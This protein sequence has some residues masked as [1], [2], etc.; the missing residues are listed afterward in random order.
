M[1]TAGKKIRK[2]PGSRNREDRF[3]PGR[4]AKEHNPVKTLGHATLT[5]SSSTRCRAG[6]RTPRCRPHGGWGHP[7]ALVLDLQQ[8]PLQWETVNQPLQRRALTTA[9]YDGKVYVIGGLTENAGAVLTVN[10]FDPAKSAW[11]TGPDIPG[12]QRNGFIAASCV[13][14]GRLY[15]SSAD[16]KLYRLAAPINVPNA[17]PA[18]SAWH[19]GYAARQQPTRGE[20]T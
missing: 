8:Q 13:A 1:I 14:G 9:A 15:V 12:P 4:E 3:H 11:T 16:G 20:Q 10:I 19:V 6:R 18:R 7:T 5:T 17:I 2:C